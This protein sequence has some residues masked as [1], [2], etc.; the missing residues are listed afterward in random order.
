[1]SG[2]EDADNQEISL[3]RKIYPRSLKVNIVEKSVEEH[4][5]NKLYINNLQINTVYPEYK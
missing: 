4:L 5:I 3:C 1:V 2:L